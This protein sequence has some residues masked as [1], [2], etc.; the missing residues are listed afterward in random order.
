MQAQPHCHVM[1]S[2]TSSA[3]KA[4]ELQTSKKCSSCCKIRQLIYS[5]SKMCAFEDDE[6][7]IELS[8]TDGETN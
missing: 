3:Y 7:R 8:E 5:Q 2:T 6:Q 4:N 1:V